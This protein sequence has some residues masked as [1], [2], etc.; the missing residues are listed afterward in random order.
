M[1]DNKYFEDFDF[2]DWDSSNIKTSRKVPMCLVVD[3][4]GSMCLSEGDRTSKIKQLNKN[5]EM[6]IDFIRNDAKASRICDLCIISFGG[7]VEVRNGYSNIENISYK[8]MKASGSTPMGEA[9]KKAIYLL[10]LRRQYY[11]DN[12]I[13]H[14]KPIML[15]MTD[16][17][18]TDD[19]KAASQ[20]LAS[21]VKN[22]ELKVFP[23]GIGNEFNKE[24]LR[25]FSPHLEPKMIRDASGFTMLFKLLSSS[26]SNP[27]DDS[28]ERW[29]KDEF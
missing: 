15:L 6:L 4:S 29:F 2:G 20:M 5:I 10:K 18:P 13:E 17:N 11:K 16:G 27:N 22:K 28:L 8:P 7:T 9:V 26:S 3:S 12:E 23:V 21:M 14:Y 25:E 24:I 1:H 19:Y